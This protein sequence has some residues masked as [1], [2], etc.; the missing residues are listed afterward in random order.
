[1]NSLS[2]IYYFGLIA[3]GIQGSEKSCQQNDIFCLPASFLAALGGGILRDL[4]ILAVY[5]VAFT[6]ACI[7][8][9]SV[10]L[11]AGALHH[12]LLRK[13]PP[14][15]IAKLVTILDS[16]GLGTFIAIGVDKALS[17]GSD[18]F[19][20]ICSG[21]ITALGGGILSSAFCGNSVHEILTQGHTYRIITSFGTLFYLCCLINGTDPVTAQYLLIHYIFFFITASSNDYKSICKDLIY[22]TQNPIVVVQTNIYFTYILYQPY[23]FSAPNYMLYRKSLYIKYTVT[24]L[25]PKSRCPRRFSRGR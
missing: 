7:L 5:P 18:P 10:A 12:I 17:L 4:F 13:N 23:T 6:K 25:N 21:I 8:D 15:K 2:A 9:I 11:I 14:Q 24:I 19:I 20:A 16:L 22:I 3:C 1:M